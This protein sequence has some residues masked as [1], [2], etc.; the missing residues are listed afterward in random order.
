MRMGGISRIRRRRWSKTVIA[1]PD[2]HPI[3]I[4]IHPIPA[5]HDP[6]ATATM[7]CTLTLAALILSA[8][9]L[10]A[11]IQRETLTTEGDWTISACTL[12]G[13]AAGAEMLR[14]YDGKH[15]F[16]LRLH[17]DNNGVHIDVTKDWENISEDKTQ[18]VELRVN[19][20]EGE[21][22]WAGQGKVV[23]DDDGLT[24]IRIDL[25]KS[26][27]GDQTESV[28]TSMME[29]GKKLNVTIGKSAGNLTE[30][31]F[32]LKGGK[33][34]YKAVFDH[35]QNGSGG[36]DEAK[37][38]PARKAAP[39]KAE[40]G[41][42]QLTEH[43]YARPGDWGVHW[44][45]TAK[46]K[47]ASASM[48]R[49]YDNGQMLRMS[50]DDSNFHVDMAGD[51]KGP[52]NSEGKKGNTVPLYVVLDEQ[53]DGHGLN[54]TG[55]IIND[56]GDK[57]LRVSQSLEE[58]GGLEDL[59]RNGKKLHIVFSAESKWTFD[60]KGSHAAWQKVDECLEKNQH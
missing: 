32:D 16:H 38:T 40:P 17:S 30:W 20:T 26:N 6:T 47:F 12:N 23:S 50:I 8:A 60:L 48:I 41:K 44:Y 7:K 59:I 25:A 21:P 55:K 35:I 58:P 39:S 37:E 43:E 10:R 27:Q 5:T 14:T 29:G 52:E 31:E 49:Y 51:W 57:W 2:V 33:A 54:L 28:L 36:A 13:K 42:G 24:W 56:E 45:S 1:A 4:I 18:S 53:D 9:L 19:F 15:E 11:G 22:L 34:A 3:T 46:G